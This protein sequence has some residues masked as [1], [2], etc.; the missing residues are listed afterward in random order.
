MTDF[1][2]IK[3]KMEENIKLTKD[4]PIPVG[5]K[6]TIKDHFKCS[7]CLTSPMNPPV[8]VTKCF[9][10]VFGMRVMCQWVVCR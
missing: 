7:I 6:K 10:D 3:R 9:W 8:V 5:Q 1:T 2:D 4:T